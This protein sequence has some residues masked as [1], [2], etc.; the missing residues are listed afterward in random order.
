MNIM[1]GIKSNAIQ[2]ITVTNLGSGYTSVQSWMK[3]W[4]NAIY[5]LENNY[6]PT[7]RKVNPAIYN[8]FLRLNNRRRTQNDALFSKACYYPVQM[9]TSLNDLA[10]YNWCE[11]QFTEHGFWYN[12]L[13]CCFWF[14]SEHD[15]TLFKLTWYEQIV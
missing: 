8:H 10:I 12:S 3:M 1:Y 11:Q 7:H 15:Q 6:S 5:G 4:R 14:V 9:S 13:S 2:S